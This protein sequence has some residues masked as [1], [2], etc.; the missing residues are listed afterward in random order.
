MSLFDKVRRW[1][2]GQSAT[3]DG[4]ENVRLSLQAAMNVVEAYA[5]VL[6]RSS[7][8]QM[9]NLL[10]KRSEAELPFSKERIKNA[11]ALLMGAIRH[12]GARTI[13]IE[14]FQ[15][16]MAQYMLSSPYENGLEGGLVALERFVP[17]EKAVAEAKEMDRFIK[18]LEKVVPGALEGM[19]RAAAKRNE[20][21]ARGQ[22]GLEDNETK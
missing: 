14:Q 9:L 8:S 3:S 12:P 18:I 7:A 15:P 13:I 2:S 19:Q 11:I 4:K 5:K 6:E 10:F 1:A 22:K 17:A 16:E 20:A 21:A